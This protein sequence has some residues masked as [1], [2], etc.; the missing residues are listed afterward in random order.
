[1]SWNET[2]KQWLPDVVVDEDFLAY[3][4]A[5]YGV[6]YDYDSMPKPQPAKLAEGE[7][8]GAAGK[9]G[10]PKEH[11]KLTKEEKLVCEWFL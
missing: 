1:M 7:E 10:E 3:Y 6:N 4:N 2:S 11:R 9:S 5:S 8:G